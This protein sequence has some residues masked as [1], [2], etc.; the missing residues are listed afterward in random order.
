[1]F[2]TSIFILFLS[3]HNHFI[4]FHYLASL[5]TWL[6]RNVREQRILI[7]FIY[8]LCYLLVQAMLI[9]QIKM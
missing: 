2:G 4:K 5:G 9:Q 3:G 6:P 7:I 1:M 8:K